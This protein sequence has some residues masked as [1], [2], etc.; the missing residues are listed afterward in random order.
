MFTQKVID[1]LQSYVY[2]LVDPR[3]NCIFY[4]GKGKGTGYSN[5]LKM[6]FK[7]ILT[8]IILNLKLFVPFIRT[9]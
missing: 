4:I 9:A 7:R 2:A 6:P 1:E 8:F 5:M 3:N